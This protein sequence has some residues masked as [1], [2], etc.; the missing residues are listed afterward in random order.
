MWKLLRKDLILNGRMA[1]IMYACFAAFWLG[2]PVLS[3]E[4][5]GAFNALAV[6]VS[7]A[8]AVLPLAIVAREDKF[9]AGA[10]ACSLPVSRDSIVVSRYVEGW[11]LAL[12]SA[13]IAVGVMWK[14]SAAGMTEMG[15]PAAGLPLGVVVTIGLVLAL[16][17]PLTLRFGIAGLLVLL[18][19]AQLGGILLL[20]TVAM[21]GGGDGIGTVVKAVAGAVRWTHAALGPVAFSVALVAAVLVLNVASCRLSAAIYRRHDF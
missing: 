18:V 20:L 12:V 19:A 15:A 1:A 17:L 2:Y 8:C 9:K 13:G 11:M 7:L 4:G 10:L 6:M 14:M 3:P 5:R 16:F 21:F